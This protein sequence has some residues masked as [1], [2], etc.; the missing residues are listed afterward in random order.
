MIAATSIRLLRKVLHN[1]KEASM[2]GVGASLLPENLVI[3]IS[4]LSGTPGRMDT[5]GYLQCLS[6]AKLRENVSDLQTPAVSSTEPC[7]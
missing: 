2:A 3:E 6:T 7:A 1:D 4:E 5:G